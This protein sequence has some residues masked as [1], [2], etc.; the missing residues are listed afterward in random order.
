M[1]LEYFV[2]LIYNPTGN[3]TISD[4]IITEVLTMLLTYFTLNFVPLMILLALI[5]MMIVNRDVKIPATNLFAATI[6]IMIFLTISSTV[7][8]SIDITGLS[9]DAVSRVVKV[10]TLTSTISYILR[11]C[12]ILMEILIIKHESR[13][14]WLY[15]IPAAVNAVIFSTAL[16][17]SRIAF[18]IGS[19]N[20]WNSGPLR[21]AVYITQLFYLVLLLTISVTSFRQ[22]NKRKSVVLVVM[23]I[24]AFLV[25]IL[26]YNAVSP[27]YTDSM[28]ALCIFEY[29]IYLSTVY[30]QQIA[31]KL[32][33]YI[34]EVENSGLRLKTLTKE[35]IMA[36]ANSIDAKDKYT[37]GHSSRVAEYSRRLA[38]MSGKS[39]QECDEIYYAGLLHDIGKIG[40]PENIITKEGK[41][42]PEEYDTIKQHPVLGGQILGSI[43][44]F[45][46]LSIG[47]R[48]HHERYDGKGYP[49]GLKGTDIPEMA[50]II[51]VAD[52]YD[53]MSSKRSYRDPIPQ[54]KV[55]EEIVKGT[56]TQFDPIYARLMLHLI[57]EDLE[58]EMSERVERRDR[59]G[60]HGFVS[61]EYRS[62]VSEGVLITSYPATITLTVTPTENAK[63]D[64]A[65]SLII[66]DSL[67]GNVHTSEKEIKDLN[68]FEYGEIRSA[69]QSSA[70]GARKIQTTVSEEGA[71]DLEKAGD[72]RIEAVRIKD[73]ARI[74]IY[75]KNMSSESV[76]ALP[77]S[78]RFM[79]L[80]ITGEHCNLKHI[81]TVKAEQEAPADSIP[82]IAEEISYID[83]PAGDI[84]NIQIDGYRT[85]HS[86]GIRIKDG[87]KITF[88]SKCLPTARLVW[89]CPFID[90]FCSDDGVVYGP[91]YR[92]LAFMRF[93]G[94]FWECDPGCSA[95]LHV[96][97]ADDYEDWDAWKQFNRDGFDTEV[98]FTVKDN[99]ITIS[100]EN[101]G[102]S[103]RNTAILTNIDKPVF[104][105]VTGDQ[106]AITNI[107]IS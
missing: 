76:I 107:R 70:S 89:H 11:P 20:H 83:G 75:G 51:S 79:F 73:H 93:D 10:H 24:Q 96:T 57:D 22:N 81:H 65:P 26:E 56:G 6:V 90:I 103:L 49:Y 97:T 55:R 94:E 77:D 14:K 105:A 71:P 18:Y 95:R 16:F 100:T 2:I 12:I 36:F 21:P 3:N 61:E 106:V 64:V 80:A 8:D 43:T 27:S 72:F 5:A 82:R 62:K 74:R 44:E 19:D 47:A 46:Y 102:I 29:Y 34:V 84:P 31:D 17:G 66:F 53:A 69:T 99:K 30:R 104:A 41:L 35:V 13:H 37:H 9:A 60:K 92:D 59:E 63:G 91:S 38:E 42:T 28:T 54:Q 45:P 32:D 86:E 39:E 7:S 4:H 87:L 98:T 23:V 78:S 67:D 52:A 15:T 1:K 68:F 50:R 33:D 40:I 58:Y 48:G 85:A 101:A 88:H 25:A